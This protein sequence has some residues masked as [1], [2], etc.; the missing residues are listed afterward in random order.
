[1]LK[2]RDSVLAGSRSAPP[3]CSPICRALLPPQAFLSSTCRSV[4]KV[5]TINH[6]NST[7]TADRIYVQTMASILRMLGDFPKVCDS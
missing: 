6:Q 7:S 2:F 3:H 1:M 5:P 4:H